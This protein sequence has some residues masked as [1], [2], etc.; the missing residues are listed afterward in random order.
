MRVIGGT[1]KGIRLAPVPAG[2]RPLSDMAREG[3]FASLGSLVMEA[4]CLDLFAGTG[5]TGIEALSR[6]AERATFVDRA[7]GAASTIRRNLGLTGFEAVG[8]VVRA[9]VGRWLAGS[10]G[11]QASFGLVF[12][13]PPYE[14]AGDALGDLLAALDA[15]WLAPEGWTVVVTRGHKSSQPVVPVHWAVRRQLRYGDSLLTQYREERW[16]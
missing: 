10:V 2:T 11:A 7:A 6:G 16:A 12:C 14:L 1:A 13:D 15:G 5:A 3:L 4:V 8:T 9:D